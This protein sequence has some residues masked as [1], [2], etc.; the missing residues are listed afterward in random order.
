MSS[1]PRSTNESS[2]P[3]SPP[4]ND[5]GPP[6]AAAFS[7]QT[8]SHSP[9]V[10]KHRSTILV[11][12]KSPLLVATPPQITRALAYSHPFITPLNR[13]LGLLS[14]STDDPWESF[15]LVA[16]FWGVTLYGDVLFRTA[17]PI[18]L[19]VGLMF[20]M[21]LRR[22]SLLSSTGWTGEK[23]GHKR[24]PSSVSETDGT[25]LKHRKSLDEIVDTLKVFTSRCNILLDPFLTLT[26]FL[27]TQSTAT[28]ATTRPA[29]T[30]MFLRIVLVTPVWWL[31]TLP[32]FYILTTK[33][34]VLFF[35]TVA[36]TWH[37]QP[38]R[39]TRTILWRSRLGRRLTALITGLDVAAPPPRD[40][41]AAK[42]S[43][44]AA[45][46]VARQPDVAKA[47]N[48]RR[49]PSSPGIRFTFSLYENQRRWL[50]IG[51][52]SSMLAYERAAW[53]DE[54]NN[55]SAPPEL[56]EL[57][58]VDGGHAVW[59]W[60]P[61]STWRVEGGGGW[62]Y[63]DT[64]WRDGRRG[65][66][67]WGRY[68]RRRKWVRDAELVEAD[69]NDAGAE[70]VKSAPAAAAAIEEKLNAGAECGSE[71][72]GYTLDSSAMTSSTLVNSAVDDSSADGASVRSRAS[73]GA[74]RWLPAARRQSQGAQSQK[75]IASVASGRSGASGVSTETASE[76]SRSPISLN[77]QSPM[78]HKEWPGLPLQL[79]VLNPH[80]PI[81]PNIH[82]RH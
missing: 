1:P 19:V 78:V 26:D 62:V 40:T 57:P 71:S 3:L 2:K 38:A 24:G 66:D 22:Y 23:R 7:P 59:K 58:E 21:Y 82:G 12:Q 55:A 72:K 18:L 52:T 68:T 69:P 41:S 5:N 11:H 46:S 25:S 8:W 34:I 27:S 35:G 61:G 30:A 37:S 42:G 15:L 36:L 75:S 64:K 79:L 45:R 20:G 73:A 48:S 81:K 65:K 6:T 74:L 54:H 44:S 70:K 67:G 63:Y 39:V 53:T 80:G 50:G 28:T 49:R 16:V 33:R 47:A 17:G 29:L 4:T 14:W 43:K 31:L 13:L 60:V 51:W 10:P 32:P 9:S 56:F 77:A 76:K